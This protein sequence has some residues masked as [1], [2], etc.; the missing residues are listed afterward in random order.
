MNRTSPKRTVPT[1]A[2]LCRLEP[3][4]RALLVEARS[5]PRTPH[6]C[7]TARMLGYGDW[8]G[9][10]LKADLQWLIGWKRQG[11]GPEVLFS[12]AA[13]QVAFRALYA[14]LPHC[15]HEGPYC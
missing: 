4:L 2:E 14:A 3:G 13:Y 6:F 10:G 9:W 11:G 1:F 15:A 7:A 12:S 8:Q 5:C